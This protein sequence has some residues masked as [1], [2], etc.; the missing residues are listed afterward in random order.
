MREALSAGII[1]NIFFLQCS[2]MCFIKV[3]YGLWSFIDTF[4]EIVNMISYRRLNGT[5]K[6][7]QGIIDFRFLV[8]SSLYP[9]SGKF[10]NGIH[11]GFEIMFPTGALLFLNFEP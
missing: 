9:L 3:E 1:H 7:G 4:L 8:L 5:Y 11:Y 2:I 6:I 10:S